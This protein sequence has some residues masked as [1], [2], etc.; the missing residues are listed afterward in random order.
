M[1]NGVTQDQ[2]ETSRLR[3]HPPR[4]EHAARIIAVTSGKGGVGKTNVTTNLGIALAMRSHRVCIFDADTSLANINI[5]LGLS[6][7]HTLE[8]L[9]RGEKDV[10]AITVEGP[11]GVKI[12]PGASGMSQL[13]GLEEPQRAKLVGA[14]ESLEKDFDYL[15]IDTAAGVDDNVLS[16]IQSAQYAVVVISPEPTS[17]TDAFAL[18]RVMQRRGFDRPIYVLVNMVADFNNSM[19]VFRRF[20]NAVQKYL[21]AKVRY[22]GYITLDESVISAVHLQRPVVLMEPDAPASRCFYTIAEAIDKNFRFAEDNNSL[23]GFWRKLSIEHPTPQAVTAGPTACAPSELSA[24]T[25][26]DPAEEVGAETVIESASRWIQD[27]CTGTEEA[28]GLLQALVDAYIERF[29][30]FPLD[31]RKGL[32]RALE[33]RGFPEKELRDLVLTL[34]SLYERRYQDTVRDPED[35]FIK[36]L[37]DIGDSEPTMI[38][39]A[40]RLQASYERQFHKALFDPRAELFQAIQR[41]DFSAS[42]FDALI[43]TIRD[44][45]QGRF[46]R[47]YRDEADPRIQDAREI[48]RRMAEQEANLRNGISRLSEW[49][50]ETVQAREELLER[51]APPPE[52]GAEEPGPG[53]LPE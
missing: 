49:L 17:L 9:L 20:Q 32:Y 7:Q 2:G 11:R 35:S 1:T 42:D 13:V 27:P 4:P 6:P 10:E 23:S 44:V 45:Y 34:E 21:H 43:Q 47:P 48:V 5:L 40:R 14:L 28:Q 26:P 39:M 18:I 3:A 53:Q 8:H 41:E 33:L 16:F 51:L 50:N 38:E 25:R 52:P 22:L 46:G 36:L 24:S 12:V 19:D 31:E 29:E 30:D 15:L 37:A